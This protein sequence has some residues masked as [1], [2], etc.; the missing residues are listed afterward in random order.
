MNTEFFKKGR[1]KARLHAFVLIYQMSF[2]S[3]DIQSFAMAKAG[4]YAYLGR[5]NM[6]SKRYHE[7]IDRVTWAVIERSDAIDKIIVHYS[8]DVDML[9]I[10]KIDLA[11]LRLAVHEIFSEEDVPPGV[12]VN[13]AVELA[14][15]FSSKNSPFFINAVLG[16]MKRERGLE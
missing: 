6:P 7:Y 16:K 9:R 5:S 13:E 12:A 11:I 1:S 2:H 3:N 10:S 4:Y 14:K 8:R 15:V